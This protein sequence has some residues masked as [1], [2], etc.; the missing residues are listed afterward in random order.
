MDNS[1][2]ILLGEFRDIINGG[3]VSNEMNIDVMIHK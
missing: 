3:R 1:G 2:R